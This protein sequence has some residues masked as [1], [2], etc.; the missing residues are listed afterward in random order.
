VQPRKFSTLHPHPVEKPN[1]R[2]Q[3]LNQ[4]VK[5]KKGRYASLQN[6]LCVLQQEEPVRGKK[7]I[8]KEQWDRKESQW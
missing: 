2:S 6:R 7:H 1:L 5:L 4:S 8:V 3:N